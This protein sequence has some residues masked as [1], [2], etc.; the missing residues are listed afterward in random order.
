MPMPCVARRAWWM[1]C[2]RRVEA[3]PSTAPPRCSAACATST[4]PR[5]TPWWARW[6]SRP[7]AACCWGWIRSRPCCEPWPL[8]ERG[9]DG[10]AHGLADVQQAPVGKG[11]AGGGGGPDDGVEGIGLHAGQLIHVQVGGHE[12]ARHPALGGR[13]LAEDDPLVGARAGH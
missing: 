4:W 12:V 9:L 2:T 8:L 5:S 10:V 11:R 7:L 6:S 1:P 13:V 3:C